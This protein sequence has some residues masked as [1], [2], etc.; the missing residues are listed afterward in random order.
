MVAEE[1]GAEEEGAEQ[2]NVVDVVV[3]HH[4]GESVGVRGDEGGEFR[5]RQDSPSR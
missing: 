1:E 5:G 2:G 3:G 4:D